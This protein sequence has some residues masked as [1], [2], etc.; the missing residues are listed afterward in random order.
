MTGPA[1]AAGLDRADARSRDLEHPLRS[2]RARFAHPDP[3]LIYLDGNS[4]G[5]LPESTRAR[6]RD[7]V[8]VAW[9][10]RLIRSWGEGW[11]DAPERLGDRAAPLLGARPGE[12]AFSDATSVNLFKLAVAALRA[13]RPR[14]K[15]VTDALNFPSDVYV[16]AGAAELVGGRVEVVAGDPDGVHA[17][18]DAIVAAI[19]GDTA[20]VSLSH[21]AFKGGYRY[22]AARITAAAHA[23]GA[24]V[25]WDLSH[26]AGAV[27]VD[28]E[29]WGADLAVGCAYKYLNGGPGAPAFLYVRRTLQDALVQPIW[30][31]FGQTRPFAFDLTYAP[32]PGVRRFTVGT[33]PVL[34]L[35]AIEPGL[36]L[37]LEAGLDRVRATSV[38]L[39]AYLIE[40][41]DARL[42][43]LGFR[44]ATPRDPERRGS[45]VTL[46][47]PDAYRIARALTEAGVIPDF[48]EPDGLRLG[49]APLYVGF[50]DL[51]EAVDRLEALVR[52]GDHERFALERAAVT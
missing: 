8:D 43:P 20:L 12:V 45:H 33:P 24:L 49:V 44:V 14:T 40:L 17:D 42:A 38:A 21:V 23:R 28:L 27:P 39:T 11:F 7:L 46:A 1:A 37:L 5:R 3:D 47:H 29:G 25:L 18:E 32:V 50:E 52:C 16:L 26:S 19:D 36:D 13:R 22:D 6:V 4:L 41:A 48:R 9:G 34:S 2:Y 35:L 10:D 51:W 30:G 15:I 31:W